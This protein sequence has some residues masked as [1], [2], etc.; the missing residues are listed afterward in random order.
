MDHSIEG[1]RLNGNGLLALLQTLLT[2]LSTFHVNNIIGERANS[3]R[4]IITVY[5]Y[6]KCEV[7]KYSRRKGRE[8][9]LYR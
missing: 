2:Q 4:R 1:R 3:K 7:L 8:L 6:S 5:Q 9:L